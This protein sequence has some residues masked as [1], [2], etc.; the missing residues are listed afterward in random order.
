MQRWVSARRQGKLAFR[1]TLKS[2]V[3]GWF[4]KVELLPTTRGRSGEREQGLRE[5]SSYDIRHP[6]Q[7]PSQA[8]GRAGQPVQPVQL[9]VQPANPASGQVVPAGQSGHPAKLA[10]QAALLGISVNVEIGGAGVVLESRV[11][12]PPTWACRERKVSP[13]DVRSQKQALPWSARGFL[14]RHELPSP[15]SR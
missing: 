5:V 15:A 3:R 11:V 2:G 14:L 12:L 8:A 7:Q 10:S 9:A 13:C 1:S 4:S 6:S